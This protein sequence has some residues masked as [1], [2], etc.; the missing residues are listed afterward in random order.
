MTDDVQALRLNTA[1]AA[2]MRYGAVMQQC[3]DHVSG[4]QWTE[5]LRTLLLLLAPFAPHLA[6]ELWARRGWP[7]SV[8]QQSWPSHDPARVQADRTTLIVQIDGRVRDRLAVPAD[9]EEGAATE[10]ALASTK[11]QMALA[12]RPI[13]RAIYVPGR[14]VN[15]VTG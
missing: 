13:R 10:L 4:E 5:A 3:R 11:V 8:H 7:Y 6:E 9:I 1:I 2:L 12:G 14:L 15:I